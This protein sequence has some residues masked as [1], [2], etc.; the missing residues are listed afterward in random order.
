MSRHRP[1][2][3]SRRQ[4]LR[5]AG[6]GAAS[7]ACGRLSSGS[8]IAAPTGGLARFDPPAMI[9]DLADNP[10]SQALLNRDWNTNVNGWTEQAILGDPWSSLFDSYN[11]YYFNPRSTDIDGAIVQ[12]I[13]WNAF[14][15]RIMYYFPAFTRE[16]QW[17]F[18]DT[19]TLNGG[20]AGSPMINTAD[21]EC[22]ILAGR[23][24]DVERI[25]FPP[26]GYRGWLDEYCEMAVRRDGA[27]K[28]ERIDVT[29]ENPEYWFTLW[30]VDRERVLAL[31][32]EILGPQVAMEDLELRVD[33]AA[34]IDPA[35]GQP[36]YDPLN[37]WNRGTVMDDGGGGAVHLTSTPNTLQTEI[38]L[39]GEIAAQRRQG[40]A[41][42]TELIC[43]NDYGQ[44]HRN[45]DPHISQVGN[46]IVGLGYRISLANPVG[47]YL[48]RPDF[49]S[50]RLP[51]D[52]N[53]PP[54][55]R[56][57]DLYR[58]VRGRETLPGFPETYDF[59]LNAR[60]EIPDAWRRAGVSFGLADVTINGVPLRWGSQ[61]LETFNVALVAMA[62]P[63]ERPAPKLRNVVRL[64]EGSLTA[65]AAPVQIMFEELWDAYY[66]SVYQVPNRPD[67]TMNLASNVVIVA[68][69]VKRGWT[70]GL[71]LTGGD[72][73]PAIDGALPTVAFVDPATGTVD[74]TIAVTV[75]ALEEV[76]YNVPGFTTPSAWQL[77]RLTVAVGEGATS[78]PRDLRVTNPGQPPAEAAKFFLVVED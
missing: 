6:A 8:A 72:F 7:L 25:S 74:E 49:R 43:A 51:D 22:G 16:Q 39:A 28:L 30:R 10:A 59:I 47:L 58:V 52:P 63:A 34:V 21:V 32:R 33:G 44:L 66:G 24:G 56:P 64:P 54:G 50:W 55:A 68:P 15:N 13:A 73:V 31:Y 19:G 77:L 48:Q 17:E 45:S 42:A 75:R 4:L 46:Q 18:A 2:S 35:T 71:A 78:G 37:K 12:Q 70:G 60:L 76:I 3:M 38:G 26:Y 67:V 36:A 1:L 23:P 9:R 5:L 65:G 41:N 11:D 29:C 57:D 61:V 53:L 14:P 40:N 20:A 62:I 69:R 27:G